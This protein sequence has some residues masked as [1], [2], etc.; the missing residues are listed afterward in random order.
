MKKI[1]LVFILLLSLSSSSYA[2]VMSHRYLIPDTDGLYSI[3]FPYDFLVLS[4]IMDEYDPAV[5]VRGADINEVTE[6]LKNIDTLIFAQEKENYDITITVLK[7]E[8]TGTVSSQDMSDKELDELATVVGYVFYNQDGITPIDE[9]E[10]CTVIESDYVK[11]IYTACTEDEEDGRI[12]THYLLF[13]PGYY[14][15]ISIRYFDRSKFKE[16]IGVSAYIC[17]SVIRFK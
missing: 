6:A 9:N 13:E 11:Y 5:S 4:S 2:L 17:G 1:I 8:S 12:A 7:Y 15:D 14:L 10:K 16:A 3:E